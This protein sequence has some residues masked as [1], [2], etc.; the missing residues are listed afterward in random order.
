[1]KIY[2]HLI[3]PV[4][5]KFQPETAHHFTLFTQELAAS[6]RLQKLLK[7]FFSFK[8]PV[9]QTRLW[10]L[11]FENPIGLPAGCDKDGIAAA[12]WEGYG[13]GW[14]TAG[15][16]TFQAQPGNP[17]PRLWRL[18]KDESMQ[19]HFGLNGKGAAAMK[20]TLAK[21][22]KPSIPFAV[23]IAR[24]TEIPEETVISDYL[25]SFEILY[26]SAP[27]FE[28]N[29]SCPNI[30]DTEY[31]KKGNFLRELLEGL[32]AR[33][34]KKKPLLLKIAPDLN[35]TEMKH[36]AA[37]ALEY[38]PGGVIVSNLLK[39]FSRIKPQ[40]P[41]MRGGISGKLLKPFADQALS[42]FYRLTEGRIPLIGLGGIATGADA[43]EKIRRGASLLQLYTGMVLEGPGVIK[44][45]LKE[46][47]FLLK[48]DGFTSVAQAV[49][50]K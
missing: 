45:V 32:A 14:A 12:A 30:P 47:A 5:F 29:I 21:K 25:S 37:M 44:R 15:S 35:E 6:L 24:T 9:L 8:D 10:N 46:L 33:N 49:G 18:L 28:I 16:V 40:S 19:V 11:D 34:P 22:A 36:I 26:D 31:Y 42:D 39:D 4:L 2:K 1:M 50:K 13:F 41:L 38:Q 23:S 20:R 7:P 48:K 3:K 43:Y 17:K 27:L